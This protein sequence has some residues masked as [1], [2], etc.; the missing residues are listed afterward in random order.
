MTPPPHAS[1]P[2]VPGLPEDFSI[3][4]MTRDE[5][6]RLIDW[7]AAEGWNPGL[8]DLDAAWAYDPEAFIALRRG[9]GLAGGGAILRYGVAAGFMGLFILHPDYRRQGLG[10]ILWHERLRRLRARLTPDAPIGMDGVFDMVPF[11]AAGGF[12]LLHRDLRYEGL[13]AGQ[14]DRQAVALEGIDF[15]ALEAFDARIFQVP[16]GAFLRRWLAQPGGIGLALN[17]PAALRGYGFLRPCRDGYKLGPVFADDPDSAARLIGSLCAQVP[18][19]RVQLDIPE[20]NQDAL[21]IAQGLG[22]RE[23]FGCARMV[24]GGTGAPMPTGAIYGV[25]S[26]EF[27]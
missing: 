12:R 2:T 26:F 7:A 11:Y 21:R 10:R 23:A 16:R 5:A 27:G 14:P 19:A 17:D 20:P 22:W 4:P 25:S 1:D 6:A 3:G 13:A 15:A 24:H 9:T 18:G 8:G